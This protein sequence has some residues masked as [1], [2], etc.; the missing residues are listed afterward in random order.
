MPH[1]ANR[2]ALANPWPSPSMYVGRPGPLANEILGNHEGVL[3]GTALGNPFTV[4]QH[5]DRALDQYKRNL[6]GKMKRGDAAVLGALRQI[7]P[8]TV[9]V[10][11]CAPR[12]CHANII[13][14]AWKW[15]VDQG[16]GHLHALTLEHALTIHQ[17]WAW[18]IQELDK[19]F[20]NRTWAPPAYLVGK[21][22]AI[23]ASKTLED[24][25]LEGFQKSG[26]QVPA[27]L[28]TGAVV[29]VAHLRGWTDYAPPANHT[30]HRWWIG[31]IGW[32]LEDVLP[33]PTPVPCRGYQKVWR[34]SGETL[35]GVH[36]QLGKVAA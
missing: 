6:W 27:D 25:T 17:P 13:A 31:P 32:I 7:Q 15:L 20:E 4:E 24:D 3:D 12:P 26:F 5:G 33:L 21:S 8:E 22:F 2:H 30:Q 10:C 14:E 11:S 16:P 34:L 1:V 9:L 28:P 36:E 18:A 29:A 19:R 35:A 23:H